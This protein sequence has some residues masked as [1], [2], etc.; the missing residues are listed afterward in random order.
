ML[1][2]SAEVKASTPNAP[3]PPNRAKGRTGREGLSDTVAAAASLLAEGDMAHA[4]I[5]SDARDLL[6]DEIEPDALQPRRHFNP[7]ELDALAEDIARRGVLQPILVRP[8]SHPGQPYRLV[9]GERRWRAARLAGKVRIPARVRELSDDEVQAAQLAENVLRAELTDIEKGRALRRLYELRKANNYKTTWEDIAAEVGLGRSRIHDLFHLA[10]LPEEVAVM[11]ESGRLSG[12]HGI[13]LQRA[14][15]TLGMEEVVDL[16]HKA[17][18]PEN[19]RTGGYQMSVAQLRQTIQT[20][21]VA[22]EQAALKAVAEESV[23]F[24]ALPPRPEPERV[25]ESNDVQG[26]IE[27]TLTNTGLIAG[28]VSSNAGS[29]VLFNTM[30]FLR[31]A[32]RQVVEGLEQNTL[33]E[34]ELA[35][36]FRAMERVTSSRQQSHAASATARATPVSAEASARRKVK[37]G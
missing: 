27:N 21:Q 20:R 23:T 33:T 24:A 22:A 4:G 8:P 25:M 16:A 5:S 34:V 15:E 36:L 28:N 12:S 2:K 35:T 37:S 13:I 30:K 14:G 26:E 3:S 32:V 9:A 6:L 11:I 29:T 1:S 19:R 31:P 17:A 7:E 18:R 10:G